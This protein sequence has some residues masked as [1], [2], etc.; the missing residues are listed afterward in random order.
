MVDIKFNN[1][2]PKTL[3]NELYPP[4]S[5]KKKK[6]EL[7]EQSTIQ[8]LSIMVR[9]KE[10]EKINS[11]PYSSK[12][13]L[14]LKEKKYITLHAEDLHF[15]I[16][17]AGWL[18]THIY[19]HYTFEKSKFKKDFVVMNQK[20]RQKATSSVERD[21][22]KLLKNSNFCIN[23]RYNIENCLLAPLYG[24]F[25]EIPSVKKYTTIF[26]DDIFR[27][28][29]SPSL[30][31]QEIIQTFQSKIIPLKQEEPTYKARKKYYERHK[32]NTTIIDT[33]TTNNNNE[34]EADI[35]IFL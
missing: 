13:H 8:L 17:R 29:F 22:Y 23:C 21:F 19:E 24:D 34:K 32:L 28:F 1:I 3:F 31:R 15:L 12:T 35:G 18:I 16:T 25:S 26:S 4:I 11:F 9:D 14:T 30:L 27:D 20:A 5:K 2:S 6:M 7:F 10:K 33:K